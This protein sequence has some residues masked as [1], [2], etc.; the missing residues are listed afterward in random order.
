MFLQCLLYRCQKYFSNSIRFNGCHSFSSQE[1]EP[2]VGEALCKA[3]SK[4]DPNKHPVTRHAYQSNRERHYPESY[5]PRSVEQPQVQTQWHSIPT[6]AVP[7][8]PYPHS[9]QGPILFAAHPA[10]MPIPVPVPTHQHGATMMIPQQAYPQGHMQAT[11]T[12]TA[13]PIP[14]QPAAGYPPNPQIPVEAQPGHMGVMHVIGPE[15]YM[16]MQPR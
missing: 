3:W 7:V 10:S 11:L 1:L 13:Q 2:S 9:T 16:G 12:Y 14:M 8:A 15:D 4:E 6:S 5:N